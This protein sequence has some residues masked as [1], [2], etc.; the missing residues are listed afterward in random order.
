MFLSKI[1]KIGHISISFDCSKIVKNTIFN[2]CQHYEKEFLIQHYFGQTL[3]GRNACSQEKKF[4]DGILIEL[5][6]N[7]LIYCN[8]KLR[9]ALFSLA[10][11]IKKLFSKCQQQNLKFPFSSQFVAFI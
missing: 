3:F 10:F 2:F 8:R 5:K 11:Q 4:K 7:N 9:P 6:I 1:T